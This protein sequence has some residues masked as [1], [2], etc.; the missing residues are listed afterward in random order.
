VGVD[1]HNLGE[2]GRANQYYTRAFELR[3]RASEREKLG[4]TADYYS[5]VTGELEKAADTYQQQ[6]ALY[7]RWATA[8]ANLATV[9]AALGQ[10]DK[11]IVAT[12]QGKMVDPERGTENLVNLA[13]A[14]NRFDDTRKIATEASAR[15]PEDPSFPLA[16]YALAFL[17]N[18]E[19]GMAAQEQWL[20][21]KPDYEHFGLSLAA[22]TAGYRGQVKK[23]REFTERAVAAAVRADNKESAGVWQAIG[24]QREAAFGY[25][26]E[27]KPQ[28]AQALKL[29]P[30]SLAV[31]S[32]TAFARA[33]AGDSLGAETLAQELE[34]QYH[35][36]TPIQLWWLPAIRAKLTLHQNN[37][38][39]A[40]DSLKASASIELGGVPFV[41]NG[42]CMYPTYVRGETE[43]AAGQG[44]DAAAEFQKIL[45]HG[46][47]VWNCWTGIMAR[48]G[49]ARA[50]VLEFKSAQGADADA[51]R[52]RALRAYQ[53]FLSVWKAADADVPVLKAAREEM[54]KL[55]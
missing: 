15:N 51:A 16:L 9:Y 54:Q 38:Q 28:A 34:K 40:L 8:Y 10:F 17:A 32:E 1:Y 7:P 44:K 47:L 35:L 11:A 53:D 37:P 29:A 41:A 46:G 31:R 39:A 52:V 55:Q 42:S 21:S 49:V 33:M 24:A 14:Q 25:P 19:A 20:A 26:A 45:D 2:A 4:I 3:D 23:A 27:A 18:D 43:L 36:N 50:N 5:N 13:L 12:N 6:I 22:D 48:L 30:E